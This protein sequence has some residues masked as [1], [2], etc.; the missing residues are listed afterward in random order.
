MFWIPSIPPK[1]IAFVVLDI[2]FPS[3]SAKLKKL[4]AIMA[5]SSFPKA[6]NPAI[7]TLE[8]ESANPIEKISVLIADPVW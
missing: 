2:T 1:A 7:K 4:D 5:P 8:G 3:L 6:A